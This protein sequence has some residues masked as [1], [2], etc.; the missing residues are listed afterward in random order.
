MD[1][2]DPT[3][4]SRIM[5]SVG[6]K[7]TGPEMRLRSALHKRGLRYRLHHRRLPGSPDIVLP[8]YRAVIF[9]HGCY[10]HR[11]GCYRSTTPKSRQEFW[12]E[13]FQANMERD[14]RNIVQLLDLGWRV[15]IVWECALVGKTA[16]EPDESAGRVIS[17]L[18]GTDPRGDVAGKAVEKSSSDLPLG[19]G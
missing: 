5:A 6:Q 18:G 10:W 3:T 1:K 2:V 14:E 12:S 4:R 15:L 16:L 8:K 17:W 9:V 13:K 11:H 7:N 19:E